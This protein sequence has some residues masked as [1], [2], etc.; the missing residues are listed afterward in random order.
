M[1]PCKNFGFKGVA[2][3]GKGEQYE[4]TGGGLGSQGKINIVVPTDKP[5]YVTL[6]NS[7]KSNID[8]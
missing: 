7:R 4:V 1:G 3:M 2:Y 8:F 5:C 6:V